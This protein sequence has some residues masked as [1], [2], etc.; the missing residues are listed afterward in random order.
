[1]VRV[2]DLVILVSFFSFVVTI[3][4]LILSLFN[5]LGLKKYRRNTAIILIVSL[6]TLVVSSLNYSSAGLNSDVAFENY[7]AFFPS[8]F[9]EVN[10]DAWNHDDLEIDKKIK[11][12]GK[13]AQ[14]QSTNSYTVLRVAVEG[15]YNKIIWAEIDNDVY[16]KVVAENDT[17]TIYGYNKGLYT[18]ETV[19]GNEMTIPSIIVRE[20]ETSY[21][22]EKSL[23]N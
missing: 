20:Y 18:Y 7:G 12:T 22:K 16:S 9:E 17:V 10:F 4:V 15:D 5:K 1:M 13:V 23:E 11:V 21:D 2:I 6:V 3:I 19:M 8:Q 14:V